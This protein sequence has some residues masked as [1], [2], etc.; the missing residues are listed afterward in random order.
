MDGLLYSATEAFPLLIKLSART[1]GTIMIWRLASL[2][3]SGFYNQYNRIN[4]M[5]MI[6]IYMDDDKSMSN[7]F[8]INQVDTIFI[9]GCIRCIRFSDQSP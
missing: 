8:A 1:D 6:I 7:P 2:L 4:G 9:N 5:M 3:Q